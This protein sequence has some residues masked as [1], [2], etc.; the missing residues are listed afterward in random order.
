[1]IKILTLTT[2]VMISLI[3]CKQPADSVQGVEGINLDGFSIT[4]SNGIRTAKRFNE[5]GQLVEQGTL[6]GG[7][8]QGSWVTYHP[9][10]GRIKSVTAYVNNKKTGRV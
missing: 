8:R 3:S 2:I 7:Q 10:S 9:N 6:V 1:M 5:F 4:T